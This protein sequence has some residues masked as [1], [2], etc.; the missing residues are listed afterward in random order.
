[1]ITLLM[2]KDGA[3]K[4]KIVVAMNETEAIVIVEEFADMVTVSSMVGMEKQK[5]PK[6]T[7]A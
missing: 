7:N 2:T 3:L 6:L 4:I 1:M 5:S